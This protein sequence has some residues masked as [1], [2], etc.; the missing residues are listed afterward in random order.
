MNYNT[1]LGF[2]V[3]LL[4]I[5]GAIVLVISILIIL[6]AIVDELNNKL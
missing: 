4:M 3:Q 2:A 6:L 5:I 1:M